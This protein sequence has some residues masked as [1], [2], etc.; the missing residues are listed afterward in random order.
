MTQVSPALADTDLVYSTRS[1]EDVRET[2]RNWL[3]S[4]SENEEWQTEFDQLWESATADRLTETVVNSGLLIQP[5]LNRWLEITQGSIFSHL[6]TYQEFLEKLK[7]ASEEE[8]Q[9]QHYLL[10]QIGLY[11]GASLTRAQEYDE[12]WEIFSVLKPGNVVDPGEYF[13]Y[14]S[15]CAQQLLKREEALE[16]LT[17]LL[18]QT[19]QIP[20][21]YNRVGELMKQELEQLEAESI[22]EIAHKMGDSERRLDLGRAGRRVQKVQKEILDALDKMI[23]DLEQQQQQQASA[24][25]GNGSGQQNQG[26]VQPLQESIIKGSTAPGE[27]DPKKFKKQG[28][29]GDLPP[30]AEARARSLIDRDYPAHYQQAIERYFRK[31]A[32]RPA[33][34]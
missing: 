24:G 23:E 13:F 31:L 34:D 11:V 6:E 30:K 22:G 5:E 9:D 7:A 2:T 17:A 20:T 10:N 15:I 21:R 18:D 33:E 19:E 29:W 1:V 4:H 12:A 14:K 28:S 25:Q 32:T 26:G 27:V 16:A 3:K 8:N